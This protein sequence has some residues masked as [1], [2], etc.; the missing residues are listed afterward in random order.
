MITF[1]EVARA[2]YGALRLARFDPTG[3]DQ[4]DNTTEAFWRS[5]YAMA[6]VAPGHAVIVASRLDT[7]EGI[8]GQASLQIGMGSASI[9]LIEAIG[10]VIGWF[11]FPFVMLYVVDRLGRRDRYL[12]YIAAFNWAMVVQMGLMLLVILIARSTALPNFEAQ[13]LG[14]AAI[15]AVFV[16]IWFVTRVGLDVSGRAALLIVFLDLALS[17]AINLSTALMI[18]NDASALVPAS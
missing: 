12:R 18:T 9:L 14:F 7:M 1:A 6:I 5:F 13:F 2:I 15:A 16:Y 11:A 8:L 10:Y 17:F 4:F 3:L